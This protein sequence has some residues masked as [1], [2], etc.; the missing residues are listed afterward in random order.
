[1]AHVQSWTGSIPLWL[2]PFG[3]FL[4]GYYTMSWVVGAQTVATPLL[5][6]KRLQEVITLLS[7]YQLSVR[8][9]KELEEPLLP[10]GTVISQY[11]A[12]GQKIKVRQ[13]ISI[14]LSRRP[15]PPIAPSFIGLKKEQLLAQAQD[16]GIEV[17]FYELE[18]V[19]PMG[20]CI[21]HY[22]APGNQLLHKAMVVYLSK[23]SSPL[24]LMPN[25]VGKDLGQV[26]EFLQLHS[27]QAHVFGTAQNEGIVLSQKPLPGTV[28]DNTHPP[29]VQLTVE[30]KQ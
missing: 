17:Q 7:P 29:L 2:L 26:Q 21:A 28:I 10:E 22:P 8:I 1:M 6:G 11:P 30:G 12:A 9:Q 27:V 18:S 23:G 24:C 19:Y 14:V 4:L 3:C 15:A 16:R 5:L 25:L 20:Q 13:A